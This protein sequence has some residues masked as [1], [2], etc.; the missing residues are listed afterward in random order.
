[1]TGRAKAYI[2]SLN[3]HYPNRQAAQRLYTFRDLD[4]LDLQRKPSITL[5][6]IQTLER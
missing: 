3:G 4:A 5:A 1:M 6:D 2:E